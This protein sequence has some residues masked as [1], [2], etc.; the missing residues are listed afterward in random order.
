MVMNIPRGAV[1]VSKDMFGYSSPSFSR[2][3][4]AQRQGKKQPL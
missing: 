1:L 3:K 2:E 4:T